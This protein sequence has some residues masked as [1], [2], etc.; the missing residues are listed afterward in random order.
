MC[1]NLGNAMVLIVL[2][3]Y[4]P[5]RNPSNIFITSLTVSDLAMV[6]ICLPI[7]VSPH[8]ANGVC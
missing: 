4:L 7:R 1:G 3:R 5:V 6:I 8:S 2:L